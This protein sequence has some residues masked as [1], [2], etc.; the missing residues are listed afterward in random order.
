[1]IARLIYL[2]ILVASAS[3][4]GLGMYYQYALHLHPCASQVLVRYALVFAALLA[5]AV[6][7][8]STAKPLRIGMGIGIG[9][10]CLIGA[11]LSAHLAWPRHVPIDFKALGVNLDSAVRSLPLADVVPRFFLASGTCDKVRWSVAGL[12][13]SE[14]AFAAFVLFIVA[15]FIAARRS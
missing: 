1:M 11:V 7:A 3:V 5:L 15:A 8:V 6:V 2:F 14:W 10:V 12:A 4:L 13:A 9:L